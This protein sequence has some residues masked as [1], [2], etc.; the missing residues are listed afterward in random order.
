MDCKFLR[1]VGV[2]VMIAATCSGC[3]MCD[4]SLDDAFGAYGGRW[5]RTDQYGGRVAS[6]IDPAGVNVSGPQA[7]ASTDRTQVDDGRDSVLRSET[8]DQSDETNVDELQPEMTPG[9][10]LD[11]PSAEDRRDEP[12]EEIESPA[13]AAEQAEEG[14]EET[15]DDAVPETPKLPDFFKELGLDSDPTLGSE[16]AEDLLPPEDDAGDQWPPLRTGA[17]Q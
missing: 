16:S 7:V 4:N 2:L 9:L 10:G 3:A 5:Q 15:T 8:S 13:P 14:V 12:A 6:V 17:D 1:Y 11:E